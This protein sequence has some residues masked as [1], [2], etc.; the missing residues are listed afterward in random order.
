M[1]WEDLIPWASYDAVAQLLVSP[2][3]VDPL[4]LWERYIY[5]SL[6]LS[7]SVSLCLPS[8]FPLRDLYRN[9][10]KISRKYR[11]HA[12]NNKNNATKDDWNVA[13]WSEIQ[14]CIYGDTLISIGSILR[15]N[16]C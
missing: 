10:Y 11:T 4:Q 13:K 8:F 3:A 9:L 2:E 5:L 7:L 12:E 15:E 16:Y 1:D 6:S 14:S